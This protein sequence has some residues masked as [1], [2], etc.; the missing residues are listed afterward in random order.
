[1]TTCT[2]T[3]STALAAQARFGGTTPRPTGVPPGSIFTA[4]AGNQDC[5]LTVT[6]G[7]PGPPYTLSLRNNSTSTA[8]TSSGPYTLARVAPGAFELA[9][10]SQ[11]A[12]SGPGGTPPPPPLSPSACYFGNL[13]GAGAV[14]EID[15]SGTVDEVVEPRTRSQIACPT[16]GLTVRSGSTT[17]DATPGPGTWASSGLRVVAAQA[18]DGTEL[19]YTLSSARGP[20]LRALPPSAKVLTV[21]NVT[22]LDAHVHQSQAE[23]FVP[24]AVDPAPGPVF[25]VPAMG[26]RQVVVYSDT[27]FYV[28]LGDAS[29]SEPTRVSADSPA[30]VTGPNDTT[31]CLAPAVLTIAQGTRARVTNATPAPMGFAIQTADPGSPLTRPSVVE[32]VPPGGS[33]TRFLPSN[34]L[35]HWRVIS[36]DG[37]TVVGATTTVPSF[38]TP[39][40]FGPGG[41]LTAAG[42][43]PGGA[44]MG[45]IT[46]HPFPSAGEGGGGPGG[47]GGGPV[48]VPWWGWLL[49][50]LVIAAC[51]AGGVTAGIQQRR[52]SGSW[53]GSGSGDGNG[54]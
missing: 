14:L 48:V 33:L 17:V 23:A 29:S 32:D 47:G 8:Q 28:A 26:S 15:A 22:A 31:L 12:A 49:I 37:A 54:G 11:P 34:A 42:P 13:T 51:I 35:L 1:M 6:V 10:S 7:S 41:A 45:S 20:A 52:Q 19:W 2:V 27:E 50:A 25:V 43:P 38:S 21:N 30:C 40:S 16:V 24:T 36:K 46:V 39:A 9:A 44:I 5:D 18:A 4:P 3:N 53:S